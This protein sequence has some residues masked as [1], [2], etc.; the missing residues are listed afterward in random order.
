MYFYESKTR[1]YPIFYH[2]TDF[3]FVVHGNGEFCSA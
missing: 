2:K 1:A 3:K